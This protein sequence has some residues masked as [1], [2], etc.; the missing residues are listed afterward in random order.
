MAPLVLFD[1]H[2][3]TFRMPLYKES[4]FINGKW[5]QAPGGKTF[6]V[7]SGSRAADI[8]VSQYKLLIPRFA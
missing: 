2:K 4:A 7:T 6:A 1:H 8:Y 3:I 5:V